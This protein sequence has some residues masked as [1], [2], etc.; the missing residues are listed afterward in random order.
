MTPETTRDVTRVAGAPGLPEDPTRTLTV[1]GYH[2]H[3]DTVINLNPGD[4]AWLPVR[5]GTAPIG[6]QGIPAARL[7]AWADTKGRITFG[8][9][10]L[11]ATELD[12]FGWDARTD[13][14]TGPLPSDSQAM[15]TLHPRTAEAIAAGTATPVGVLRTPTEVRFETPGTTGV[16]VVDD[17][18]AAAAEHNWRPETAW[19]ITGLMTTKQVYLRPLYLA[20]EGLATKAPVEAMPAAI[21][22]PISDSRKVTLST[23]LHA[24]GLTIIDRDHIGRP[25]RRWNPVTEA[26]RLLT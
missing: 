9:V 20:R 10:R 5:G 25:V 3:P 19:K 8:I 23:L 22:A 14:L 15:R 26:E 18:N 11:Y 7:L 12:L 24:P 13:S 1:N 17:Y 21:R 16:P 4:G 6:A 2:L